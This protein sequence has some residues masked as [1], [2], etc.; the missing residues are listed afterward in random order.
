M[1]NTGK[2]FN[3]AEVNEIQITSDCRLGQ[4]IVAGASP[5]SQ[6]HLTQTESDHNID[7][8]VPA[9]IQLS[10]LKD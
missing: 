7:L 9:R 4:F 1:S 10:H 3:T 6:Q 5:L 8:F 2:E